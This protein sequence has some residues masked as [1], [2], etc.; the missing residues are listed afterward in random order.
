M[1]EAGGFTHLATKQVKGAAKTDS[2]SGG[3]LEKHGA[4]NRA[5]EHARHLFTMRKGSHR[6]GN[7]E[8]LLHRRPVELTDAQDM[9]TGELHDMHSV[10]DLSA[11]APRS[12]PATARRMPTCKTDLPRIDDPSY[13]APQ[14]PVAL[15]DRVSPR[16]R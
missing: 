1:L 11:I 10:V 12:R 3:R 2:G 9:A 4:E 15:R 6:V 8:Q 14:E 13:S 5:V 16:L 7:R